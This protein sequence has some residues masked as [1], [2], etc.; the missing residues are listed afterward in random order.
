MSVFRLETL[1]TYPEDVSKQKEENTD[2]PYESWLSGGNVKSG[3]WDRVHFT[4]QSE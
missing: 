4:F 2:V 3:L 1:W